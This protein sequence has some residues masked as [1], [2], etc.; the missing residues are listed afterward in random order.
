MFDNDKLL[1]NEVHNIL[2]KNKISLEKEII[3]LKY[4][5]KKVIS[6]KLY[7]KHY[8]GSIQYAL[9]QVYKPRY[10]LTLERLKLIEYSK[11]P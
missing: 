11:Y 3:N 10:K 9:Q 7:Y 1:V 6:N 5:Y 4:A 2:Y 8:S